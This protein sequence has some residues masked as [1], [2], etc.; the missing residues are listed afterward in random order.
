MEAGRNNVLEKESKLK[1]RQRDRERESG[2]KY[3]YPV[4]DA[5]LHLPPTNWSTGIVL[6]MSA[7]LLLT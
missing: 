2:M 4:N 3:S 1:D 6:I 5:T 7:I